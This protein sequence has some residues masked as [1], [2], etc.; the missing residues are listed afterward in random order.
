M[1]IKKAKSSEYNK[2][3]NK[4]LANY[5]KDYSIDINQMVNHSLMPDK[6]ESC[7][8][9]QLK[10]IASELE[11]VKKRLKYVLYGKY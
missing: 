1:T 4:A 5:I 11:T 8:R 9:A 3:N 2:V 7:D 6:L 10:A